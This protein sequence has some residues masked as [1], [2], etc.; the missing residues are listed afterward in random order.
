[1]NEQRPFWKTSAFYV[2]A[3]PVVVG[4]LVVFGVV[5]AAD[6]DSTEKY[7]ISVTERV[8][9]MIVILLPAIQFVHEQRQTRREARK[10]AEIGRSL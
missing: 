4:A 6:K 10:Q 9:G 3:I 1:M 2:G 7:L 8:F 5:P